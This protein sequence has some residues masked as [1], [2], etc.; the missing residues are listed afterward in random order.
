M[1]A[2]KKQ[3]GAGAA[4]RYECS[5]HGLLAG[6]REPQLRARLEALCGDTGAARR[7]VHHE[8]ACVPCV[9]TPA[10]A[11]RR[12]DHMLRLRLEL[13]PD[14]PLDY[15]RAASTVC[16]LGHP[17][18]RANRGA[19]VRPAMYARVF[20]DNAAQFLSLLGYRRHSE[21]VRRGYWFLYRGRFK[22]SVSQVLRLATP[23]DARSAQ[24]VDP[25][26][27]WVVHVVA[28]A[29]GQEQVPRVCEQLDELRPLFADHV[30]LVAVDHAFLENKIP[31]H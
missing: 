13:D 24:P 12:E 14:D 16:L 17:E 8:I 25:A 15:A 20:S 9:E 6:G 21:F 4:T 19:S 18:P 10:G 22:V 3:A 30:E 27:S 11:A 26:G 1:A 29:L 2:G 23:G 5:L 7:E 28:D 31:Y